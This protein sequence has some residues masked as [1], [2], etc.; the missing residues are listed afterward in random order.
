MNSLYETVQHTDLIKL[1]TLSLDEE[2]ALI[3]IKR[4]TYEEEDLISNSVEVVSKWDEWV[5]I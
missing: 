5:T 1:N 2:D 3:L 4:L